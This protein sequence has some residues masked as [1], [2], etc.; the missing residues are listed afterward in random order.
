MEHK[1]PHCG[2]EDTC[3]IPQ[4]KHPAST[5]G[6]VA[7]AAIGLASIASGARVGATLG[8]AAGPLGVLTGGVAGAV[9]SALMGGSAG[10]AL[11]NIVGEQVDRRV[12]R[13]H[14]CRECG[15]LFKPGDTP[16]LPGTVS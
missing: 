1:C 5:L 3:L 10:Y 12:L 6:G 13:N 14:L 2:S 15:A 4:A 9:I 8:V 11:G 16:Q 7:G